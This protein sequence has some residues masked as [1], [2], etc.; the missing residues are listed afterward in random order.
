M[1]IFHLSDIHLSSK[2]YDDFRFHFFKALKSDFQK[3]S[4][5]DDDLIV[6]TGDLVDKGGHSLKEIDDYKEGGFTCPYNFFEHVFIKPLIHEFNLKNDNFLFVPGN[7][8]ID[9]NEILWV[10]EKK[11]KEEINLST[12]NKYLI[13]NK[14]GINKT[15]K[16]IEKFK[17]FEKEFHS[18]SINYVFSYNESTY[19]YS[20]DKENLKIGFI[21]L[22]D[23]WRCS[24]CLVSNN[25]QNLHFFGVKQLYHGLREL[26]PKL[27]N[28]NICLFHHPLKDFAEV[29]EFEIILNNQEIQLY[30]FGHSHSLKYEKNIAPNPQSK[31]FGIMGKATLNDPR[32]NHKDYIPGY[33]IIEIKEGKISSIKHRIYSNKNQM[34]VAN[35]DLAPDN[36]VDYGDKR[37]GYLLIDSIK[38]IMSDDEIED[39][40]EK[41][42]K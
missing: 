33:Q 9:E 21:L 42:F 8:D 24:T 39:L 31:C 16:R 40:D 14:S 34:F 17:E 35:T 20:S 32:E 12:V 15:N 26:E 25:E 3:N 23:S 38:E 19:S 30:L 29:D 10:D 41:H 4:I 22:N 27:N 13:G 18:D 6:I 7:H 11:M 5:N 1:K 37:D 2:N 36:G 28:I